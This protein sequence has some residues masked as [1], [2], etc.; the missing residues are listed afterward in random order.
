MRP[1]RSAT[2]SGARR[3]AALT[4]TRERHREMLLSGPRVSSPFAPRSRIDSTDSWERLSSVCSGAYGGPFLSLLF[5]VVSAHCGVVR[6][7]RGGFVRTVVALILPALPGLRTRPAR[8]TR[9]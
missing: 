9:D 4:S 5:E 8:I 3:A 7:E 2:E 1:R 6:D